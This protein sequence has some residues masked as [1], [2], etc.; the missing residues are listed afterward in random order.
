MNNIGWDNLEITGISNENENII[1]VC[2][3]SDT[4][5]IHMNIEGCHWPALWR[6]STN[7]TNY[8]V[9]Q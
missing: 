7:I 9:C 8:E 4:M 3:D 6:N 5:I 2:T 1:E